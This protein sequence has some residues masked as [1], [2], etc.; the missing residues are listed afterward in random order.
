MALKRRYLKLRGRRWWFQIA[1]P[2]RSQHR[3]KR[4]TVHEN[5]YTSDP[6]TAQIKANERAA[7]WQREFDLDRLAASERPSDVFR[8]TLESTL[9]RV[10]WIGRTHRDEEDRASAL[11]VLLEEQLAPHVRRLGY[12]DAS[13][14]LPGD[15]PP[16]V[17]AAADAVQAALRGE[18]EVPVAYRTPFSELAASFLVDRQRDP[19]DRL[20]GQTIGQ[21]EATFRLFRDHIEDA[22]LATVDRRTA[23]AFIDK[24]GRLNK[25]WGRSPQTKQLNLDQL[26][27]RAA[28]KMG[29]ERLSNVTLARHVSALTS[30]WDWAARKGDVDGATPFEAPDTKRAK[31]ARSTANK[32]WT[33]DAIETY[34]RRIK[35][36]SEPGTPD[37]MYWLPLVALLSGMRLEEICSLEVKDIKAAEGI[38]YF[39]IPKGK[40]E[41]SIRVVPVHKGLKKLLDLAPSSGYLFP[42]L[43]P[44]GPDAK[45]S[46]NI[47]KHFGRLFQQ[48]EGGST[49]HAFRKNV[50][51]TFERLRVRENESSQLLGH[52]KAGLTYGVY[53]PNGLTIQQKA[54]L[55]GS[56]P[57]P[58]A[59]RDMRSDK[60][61]GK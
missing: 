10:E 42:K 31:R 27:A 50:A 29:E 26:L 56:L 9:Q 40:A 28:A 53:S 35:D 36:R 47:G 45:R 24:L 6:L 30:L 1:V 21:M 34:F 58:A 43:T 7:H 38:S 19:R 15:L 2:A 3:L 8:A 61:G 18:R 60:G 12:L 16:D 51:Q 13:E 59:I 44:G 33:D 57:V 46:W 52:K 32:P 17:E 11:E 25:N 5:L 54:E 14:I 48:V 39:D 4:K 49:F 23:S 22:A 41:G 55:I 37:P 20:T